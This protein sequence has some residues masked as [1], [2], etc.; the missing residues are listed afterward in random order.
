MVVGLELV[1]GYLVAW[2]VRKARRA[3]QGLD[4]EVDHAMDLGLDRLHE[5]VAEKL[6]DDPAVT[7]VEVEATRDGQLSERTH[8]RVQDAV[9]EAAEEDAAFAAA[10]QAAL[11]VL[12]QA[13]AGAP[14]VAGIDLRDAKGV[15]VGHHN[16]QTNTFS[17]PPAPCRAVSRRSP[18]IPPDPRRGTAAPDGVR[19]PRGHEH[20]SVV[21]DDGAEV[22]VV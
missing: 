4:A 2:V 22:D 17:I 3:G 7:K 8:R 13:R 12:D 1:A 16:T 19:G 14:S 10:L 9:E 15:Q 21:L 20:H 5:V 6:G 11:E 18:A